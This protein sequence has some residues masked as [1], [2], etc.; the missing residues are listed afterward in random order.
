MARPKLGKGESERLQMVISSEELEAIEEWQHRNRI[1]SKSEAIRRLCQIGLLIDNELEQVVDLTSDGVKVL[2]D[3]THDMYSIWRRVI[4]TDNADLTFRQAE[5]RDIFDLAFSH[6]DV[7]SEGVLA[8]HHLVVTVYNMIADIVQSRTLKA[9]LRKSNK[10][11]VAAKKRVEDLE[12]RKAYQ[13]ENRYINI[14]SMQESLKDNEAYQAMS[15]DEQDKFLSKRIR[16]LKAEE[17]ADPAA[18]AKKYG[19]EPPFWEQAGWVTKIRQRM[20]DDSTS[21]RH[22]EGERQ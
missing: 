14:I 13:L 3:Q 17:E 21:D 15:D 12:R 11:V 4:S 10:H 18:F 20:V 22:A 9:G 8:I 1:Q 19:I 2:A 7:A 6:G 16:E 5:V